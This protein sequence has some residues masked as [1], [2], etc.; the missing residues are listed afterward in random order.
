MEKCKYIIIDDD[1]PFHLTVKHHFRPYTDYEFVAA[2]LNPEDALKYV[3]E[4]EIDLIFLDIKMPEMNGFQFIENLQKSVF[5]VIL[6][7]YQ[8]QYA[9]EAHQ[10]YDKDLVFFSNKAQFSYYLPKIISRFEKMYAEKEM[11]S[12]INQ[13]SKNEINTFP[14]TKKNRKVPLADVVYFTV[15]GHDIALKMKNGEEQIY[16]M[17]LHELMEMLPSN[18][19]FQIRRNMIINIEH[20]T[21]FTDTTV[22][23]DN[24]HFIIS[25]R[26]RK[27]IVSALKARRDLL[28]KN[29]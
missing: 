3:Q 7:G 10:Y 22:C 28:Y 6:T 16:R 12:R 17:T 1:F 29:Y 9:F 11:L 8:D 23:I 20:V 5:I 18:L 24:Q 2:F 26:N 15:I 27:K 19:F 4:N 25:V 13:L 14:E 21:S